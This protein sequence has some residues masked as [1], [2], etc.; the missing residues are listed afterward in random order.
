M[1]QHSVLRYAGLQG[2]PAARCEA[3]PYRHVDPRDDVPN[4]EHPD[5][6][7]VSR[8]RAWAA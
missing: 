7:Q 2:I 3:A 5:A 8:S 4:L 6:V 1:C